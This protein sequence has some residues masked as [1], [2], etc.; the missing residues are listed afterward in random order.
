MSHSFAS[1]TPLTCTDARVVFE[2]CANRLVSKP[3]TL[4]KAKPLYGYFHRYESQ[5]GELSQIA[6]LEDRMAEL[7]P[8]DPKLKYFMS[9]YCS[10]KFDPV[11]A[12]III[13][14]AVQ[15]RPKI[16]IPV[17]EQPAYTGPS[18]DS[19]APPR[20]EQSPRPQYVRATA[21]PKRPFGVDDEELNPPKRLARGVSPLKG[22][23]GRRL[24]QQRRNQASALHRDITFL[25]GI[26]PPAHSYDSQR[27]NPAGVAALLRDTPLP[28]YVSWKA[29]TGGQYMFNPQGQS[30]QASGDMANRP[31]SPYGRLAA[32]SGGYRNSPLRTESGGSYQGNLYV[33]PDAGAAPSWQPPAGQY[34]A[35]RY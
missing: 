1:F 35:Y 26:L 23:A 31:I 28:D 21:S 5:Y 4:H 30:R 7:F 18:R 13:S 17:I 3:E 9:R 20:Q 25:L 27:L 10:D 15:M 11:A 19:I 33:A 29:K 8:R 14:K 34:G 6:K 24:D 2:T 22:A 12:P 32:S 16:T